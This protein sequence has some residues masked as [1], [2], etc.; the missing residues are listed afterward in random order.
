LICASRTTGKEDIGI[1]LRTPRRHGGH[2]V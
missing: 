2:G 1:H